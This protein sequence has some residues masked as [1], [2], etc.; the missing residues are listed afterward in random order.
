MVKCQ[1]SLQ[2]KLII[3]VVLL[4]LIVILLIGATFIIMLQ[5]IVEEQIGKQ[6]LSIATTVALM[7]EI[8]Q[9][10]K[11]DKPWQTI[12]PLVEPIR[13]RVGAEFIVVGNQD[14]NRYSHPKPDRIG[15]KMVGGEGID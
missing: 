10:F 9:A 2:T 14:G 6:A 3:F 13:Q 8:R 11:S 12:Q 7:P 4:L 1:F 15:R 5:E